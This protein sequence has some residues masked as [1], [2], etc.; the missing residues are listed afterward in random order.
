MTTTIDKYEIARYFDDHFEKI[1]SKA[2]SKDEANRLVDKLN[3]NTAYVKYYV[4]K[5]T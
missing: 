5:Q 3:Q 2:L 1:I 4:R